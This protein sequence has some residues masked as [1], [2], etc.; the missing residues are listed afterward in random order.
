MG[1]DW[2]V[3]DSSLSLSLNVGYS[4]VTK[5]CDLLVGETSL[6]HYD[7]HYKFR[8][9]NSNGSTGKL[10]AGRAL[11]RR[12]PSATVSREAQGEAR[13]LT[14]QAARLEGSG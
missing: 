2:V 3:L 11:D 7:R 10:S 4:S 14:G 6:S 1:V 12:D 9:S 5:K 13:S 8:S